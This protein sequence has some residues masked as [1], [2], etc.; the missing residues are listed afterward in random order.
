MA[1]P[2][3]RPGGT[4]AR[5][6]ANHK[7]NFCA[8]HVLKHA[9]TLRIYICVTRRREDSGREDEKKKKKS[10]EKR[11]RERR[12][13]ENIEW[14]KSEIEG[15]RKEGMNGKGRRGKKMKEANDTRTNR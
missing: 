2:T 11:N 9:T 6:S 3:V 4:S 12:H 5:L 14:D 8:K 1:L 15:R 7:V 10:R 13:G